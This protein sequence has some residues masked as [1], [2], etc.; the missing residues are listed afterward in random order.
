M[1]A[2]DTPRAPGLPYPRFPEESFAPPWSATGRPASALDALLGALLKRAGDLALSRFGAPM[3][4]RKADGTPVTNVDRD[5]EALIVAGLREA[6]PEDAVEAEEGGGCAGGARTWVVDPLDG[7]AAY[8]EG[9]AH[10]GPVVAAIEGGVVVAGA[11][12]LP[13]LREYYF[14]ERGLGAFRNG[15]PLPPLSRDAE[16][17][18]TSLSVLYVPSR[19]HAHA[20]LRWPGKARCLGSLASHLALVAAGAAAGALIPAGWR[21][22][23]TAAGLALIEAVGGRALAV[24]GQPFDLHDHAGQAF[25]VGHAGAVAWLAKPGRVTLRPKSAPLQRL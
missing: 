13:R 19:L 12:Y 23:D 22:W 18:P 4:E 15:A 24:D 6:F 7:T 20:E 17:A 9:L 10:W 2:S 21:A 16:A 3:V 1:S 5:V 14:V 8:S 25:V 11:I